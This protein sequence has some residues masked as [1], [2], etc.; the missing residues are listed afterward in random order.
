[1]VA[2]VQAPQQR[3]DSFTKLMKGVQLATSILGLK[4]GIDKEF[5]EKPIEDK[6]ALSEKDILS[7]EQ[8]GKM[9]FSTEPFEG[10]RKYKTLS[11]AP[12]FGGPK[13]PELS[14]AE[15]NAQVRADKEFAYKQDQDKISNALKTKEIDQKEKQRQTDVI[16]NINGEFRK[17][18]EI[19][20]IRSKY[21]VGQN[22]ENLLNKKRPVLDQIALR[23]TFK[24]AGDVGSIRA[25]DLEQLGA[26]PAL[27][28]QYAALVNKA[29]TGKTIEDDEREDLLTM[30]REIQE[31]AYRQ[32][33]SRAVSFADDIAKQT[34]MT[35]KEA[36]E[37]LNPRRNLVNI[38]EKTEQQGEDQQ[39]SQFNKPVQT[40]PG[41]TKAH[42][43]ASGDARDE[44][45]KGLE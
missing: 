15:K 44:F 36:M 13:A 16:T 25:E 12:I 27:A 29:L 31:N 21:E 33:D 8:S 45:L 24:L 43:A 28:S 10:A 4:Q 38:F 41:E 35:R 2:A 20:K 11:G 7:A 26:S 14:L 37:Y 6:N 5:E 39:Y 23:Q 40:L 22:V 42:G 1:M 32:M 19:E 34:A 17:D 9:I 3:E 18:K 30:A